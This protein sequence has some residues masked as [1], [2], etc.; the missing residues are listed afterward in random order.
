M[1]HTEQVLEKIR[2]AP[3]STPAKAVRV[4]MTLSECYVERLR[5][6]LGVLPTGRNPIAGDRLVTLARQGLEQSVKS[7]NRARERYGFSP[8]SEQA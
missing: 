8:A 6:L 2:G 3:R 4:Y 1:D 7:R 5:L